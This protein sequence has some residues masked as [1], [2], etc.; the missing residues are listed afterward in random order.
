MVY[1]PSPLVPDITARFVSTFLT[2]TSAPATTAPDGSVTRPRM[3]ASSVCA[4]AQGNIWSDKQ[5]NPVVKALKRHL[6]DGKRWKP[7]TGILGSS[8]SEHACRGPG[9]FHWGENCWF[10]RRDE[11]LW[12][13]G[14]A[15]QVCIHQFVALG[16]RLIPVRRLQR[17]KN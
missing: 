1:K 17:H 16:L 5:S 8:I 15:A 10:A 9:M 12:V 3:V 4:N 13:V 2:S 7:D 6:N 11:V 14:L